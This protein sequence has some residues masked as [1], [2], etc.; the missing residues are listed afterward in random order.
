MF[1][2]GLSGA[3][4]EYVSINI[5]GH[6]ISVYLLSSLFDKMSQ[7]NTLAFDESGP[8]YSS[9]IN[10]AKKVLREY[11]NEQY[12]S[13][14]VAEVKNVKSSDLY[15]YQGDPK[16]KVDD[17]ERQYFDLIAVEINSVI[18]SFRSSSHETKKLTYRLIR[19]AV[20]TNPDSLTMILT[21]VFRLSIEQQDELAKLLDYTTLP[22]IIN[23]S[24][25]ISNSLLID[26]CSFMLWSK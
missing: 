4:Y 1:I 19:E 12:H 18:P 11:I 20:K 8:L 14:A 13:G 21:E 3:A 16:D 2:C 26:Y 9:F 23:M 5:K 15:P 17:A 6:P 25:T 10:Q 24:Q 7:S 22:A